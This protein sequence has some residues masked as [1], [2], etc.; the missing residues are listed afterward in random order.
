MM[1]R[2]IFQWVRGPDG[3]WT[4]AQVG[5]DTFA[6]RIPGDSTVYSKRDFTMGA[7]IEKGPHGPE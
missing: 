6:V 1:D 5:P 4:V 2:K 7:I 3:K